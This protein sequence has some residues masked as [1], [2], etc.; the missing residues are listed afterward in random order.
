MAWKSPVKVEV[1]VLHR[2]HLR[3][4][5]AGSA[6]LDA[7]AGA[8]ARLAQRHDGVLA[9]P[10]EAVAEADGGGGLALASR[11]RRDRRDQ[12]QLAVRAVLQRADVVEGEL[13]LVVA[14]RDQMLR[15]NAEA[16][17]GDIEDRALRG[18]PCDVD[19]ALGIGVL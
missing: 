16:V 19:I 3:V 8:E 7:E 15:R 2:H 12:D 9:D 6:A 5:A 11:R 10:V 18:R 13:R 17:L 14:V 4:A 1:D